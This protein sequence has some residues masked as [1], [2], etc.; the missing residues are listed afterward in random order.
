MK[1]INIPAASA[2]TVK[3]F[4]EKFQPY[5]IL[6]CTHSKAIKS[7]LRKTLKI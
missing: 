4:M 2:T 3:K 6:T 5:H 1:K 7:L